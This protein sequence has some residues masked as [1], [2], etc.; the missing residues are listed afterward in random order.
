[1]P[2]T[3]YSP[4]WDQGKIHWYQIEN[5]IYVP[6]ISKFYVEKGYLVYIRVHQQIT[7]NTLNR[8]CQLSKILPPPPGLSGHN[9][10]GWNTK[11]NYMKVHFF[12]TLN[13]KFWRY[14]SFI[15]FIIQ[16]PGLLLLIV[17]CFVSVFKSTDVIF[18]N[19]LKLHLTLSETWL[20]RECS[21][22]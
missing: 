14:F 10:A 16:S 12:F 20:I 9:H 19:F 2:D 22:Y 11:Q 4:W 5:K 7:F 21:F 13:L 17:Y 15:F 18:H 1:M 6:K 3:D 8:F